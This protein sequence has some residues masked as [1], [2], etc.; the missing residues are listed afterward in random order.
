V[1]FVGTCRFEQHHTSIV[2]FINMGFVHGHW[3]AARLEGS[4]RKLCL[5]VHHHAVV[6][7]RSKARNMGGSFRR[8][9]WVEWEVFAIRASAFP[10]WW[11]GS[12]TFDEQTRPTLPRA[13]HPVAETKTNVSSEHAILRKAR[14]IHFLR[15]VHSVTACDEIQHACNVGDVF[16]I[17]FSAATHRSFIIVYESWLHRLFEVPSP[18]WRG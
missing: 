6:Q 4:F 13:C 18:I 16:R 17:L 10:S 9:A 1:T 7:V 11:D 8:L 12:F 2:A 5:V 3:M 14:R 15:V